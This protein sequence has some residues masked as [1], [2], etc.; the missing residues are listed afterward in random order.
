M[1]SC[2]LFEISAFQATIAV[3][4]SQII[5]VLWNL[6]DVFVKQ[7]ISSAINLNVDV[8]KLL[9]M[10]SEHLQLRTDACIIGD[11]KLIWSFI[12]PFNLSFAFTYCSMLPAVASAAQ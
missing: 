2:P 9:T 3:F 10:L 11:R 8:I 1:L 6:C 4:L 12:F 5:S 7:L